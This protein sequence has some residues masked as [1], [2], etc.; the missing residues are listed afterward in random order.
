M[1]SLESKLLD[2]KNAGYCSSS[3]E[4]D[5]GWQV[6]KDDDEHQSN[7]MRHLGPSVNTGAKG[8]LKEYAAYERQTRRDKRAKDRELLMLAQKGMLQGSNLEYGQNI[9]NNIR[10]L[11]FYACKY[12]SEEED[13][14]ENL[15]QRRLAELKKAAAGKIKEILEKD[16][17]T[18]AIDSCERLLC[19][20][21]YEPDD[22][23]CQKLT[24][25]C[26]ILA[27]DY[28]LVR[29]VRARSVILGMSKAFTEQALPTL[30][31]YLNGNLV[32]NFIKLSSLLD[33]EIDVDRVRDF[34]RRQHIN[35]VKGIY[36]T[37]SDSSTDEDDG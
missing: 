9:E 16:Q 35:L 18:K 4:G 34:I 1:T 19:V 21:I 20:L 25:V 14:L 11:V 33:G 36:V 23:M 30:Q 7:V 22:E 17:F 5:N 29:F 8:V 32:G 26:K 28:P 2:G 37:D 15:R 31:F 6:A 13:S 24:H 27:A 10:N 3:D 12:D